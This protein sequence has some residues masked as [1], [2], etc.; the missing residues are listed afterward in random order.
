MPFE[1]KETG[2]D[3]QTYFASPRSQEDFTPYNYATDTVQSLESVNYAYVGQVLTPQFHRRRNA[4]ELLPHT[5]YENF[6]ISSDRPIGRRYVA[7][8][9]SGAIEAITTVDNYATMGGSIPASWYVKLPEMREKADEYADFRDLVQA[10]AAKVF[11][12][13][14]DTLTFLSELHKVKRMFTGM[15]RKIL[16]LD[17]PKDFRAFSKQW[18]EARYGWRT[19]IYDLVDLNDAIKSLDEKS[20]T[21]VS[22]RVGNSLSWTDVQTDEID[23]GTAI[24]TLVYTDT[25][26]LSRRGSLTADFEQSSFHFNVVTT[27][28]ELVPFSFVIDW[29]VNIGQQLAAL[30]FLAFSGKYA[31]S[32][33]LYLKLT[34]EIRMDQYYLDSGSTTYVDDIW[35]E[36]TS[37]MSYK[38]RT[39]AP[40]SKL[41]QT[42]LNIDGFKVVDL[43]ALL[44][45]K[46]S[47]V[48][49]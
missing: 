40:V 38:L 30:Q 15:V 48:W 11:S 2:S 23:Y 18:L 10:V 24:R 4:G 27:A 7:Q 25:Y 12:E 35:A 43:I 34:R 5:F 31:S 29:V 36:S 8:Y 21:R 13:G 17:I 6:K 41:P 1:Y 46:F 37:V 22:D 33:G 49:R 14:H 45:N 39:P 32:G 9:V 3:T 16:T 19:L 26:D 44:F 47:T 42:Q 28:W 20:R